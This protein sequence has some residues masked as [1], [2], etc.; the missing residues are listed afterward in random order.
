MI[1]IR[2]RNKHGS[3][4]SDALLFE[5]LQKRRSGSGINNYRFI[6]NKYRAITM[7]KVQY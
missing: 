1:L 7:T 2:V 3:D 6:I 5:R 4:F